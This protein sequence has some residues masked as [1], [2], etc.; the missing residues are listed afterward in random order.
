MTNMSADLRSDVKYQ[1]AFGQTLLAYHNGEESFQVVE[2][3]DGYIDL[4]ETR[5]YFTKYDEWAP[6]EKGA[7]AYA[8]G[9]I[10]DVGCG[11]ARHALYL[12]EKGCDVLGI[13]ISPLA[14]K[15]CKLRGLK[16]AKVIS[17]EKANFG[18]NSFDTIIMMGNNFGLFGSFKKAR[19]LLKRFHG[20]TSEGALIIATTSDVYKTDNPDH[21]RYHKLNKVR[22][23]MSGQ[24]RIRVRFHRY[25][26]S[27]FDYLMVS[28]GEMRAILEGT[29][30]GVKKFIDSDESNYA[31][32]IEK[33]K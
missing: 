5:I 21:L 2:R 20:M 32:I 31:A 29:G 30:W 24:V 16:K 28:K 1:D 33:E 10:L 25:A 3:D 12:Q 11:A 4:I 27:W 8:K 22:G 15:V 6:H 19:S 26:T 13:D 14:I 17:V 18:S 7:L 23:R 9:R